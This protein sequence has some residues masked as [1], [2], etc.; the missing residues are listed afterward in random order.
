MLQAASSCRGDLFRLEAAASKFDTLVASAFRHASGGYSADRV[1]ADPVLNKR[2]IE[3]A[4]SLGLD[5]PPVVVNHALF[6]LRKTGKLTARTS[7]L[8]TV[9]PDQWR[10]AFASEVA[11][12][13]LFFQTMRSV[14]SLLC[15]P[16]LATRFDEI[17]SSLAPGFS[18]L[19]YRWAALNNRKKGLL[20]SIRAAAVESFE[21]QDKLHFGR[22]PSRF[23]E[24]AG[25]FA[26]LEGEELL[27]VGHT[28][29]LAETIDAASQIARLD[30]I[31]DGLWKPS[32]PDLRW[33][34][35]SHMERS[36]ERAAVVTEM[37]SVA[38]PVFNIPRGTNRA[39]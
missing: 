39:A 4:S 21:W 11:A 2:F 22:D 31:V 12:R 8:R 3:T 36:E 29:D 19:E 5:A 16:S 15:D 37:V 9:I 32:L 30:Q 24:D 33:R 14:D 1:I 17:A 18:S 23:A 6:R 35:S 10:F 28:E 7:S 27:Y 38:S 13:V 20:R 34:I 26:L 25:V